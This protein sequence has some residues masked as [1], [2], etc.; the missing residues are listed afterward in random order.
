GVAVCGVVELVGPDGVR[1]RG[2]QS[3]RDVLILVGIAVGNPRHLVNLRT[4]HLEQCVLLRR[5]VV[6]H[7]DDAAVAARVADVSQPDAGIARGALDH[8]APRRERTKPLGLEND[9]AGSAVLDRATGVHELRLA[10]DLTAG[11]L[12][13]SLEQ[14]RGC[15]PARPDEAADGAAGRA[16]RSA[17][18]ETPAA[19]APRGAAT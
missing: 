14:N 7:H 12:A 17:H 13:D 19:G 18:A 4:R 2:S 3:L 6:G 10:E 15:V 5:L 16:A 9:G 11:L 8:G 1:E